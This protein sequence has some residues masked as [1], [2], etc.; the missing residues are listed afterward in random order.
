MGARARL[1]GPPEDRE[2]KV[3]ARWAQHAR[4]KSTVRR[5]PRTRIDTRGAS[6]D[7]YFRSDDNGGAASRTLF[8]FR[9][10]SVRASPGAVG[11]HES[12]ESE[13]RGESPT[14]QE[15]YSRT[16]LC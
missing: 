16:E 12:Y 5:L 6:A 9:S 15:S 1:A 8:F 2:V 13:K 7:C 10:R 14:L 11:A 4:Q 3:N